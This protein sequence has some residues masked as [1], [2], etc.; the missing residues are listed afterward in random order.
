MTDPVVLEEY[1]G[2]ERGVEDQVVVRARVDRLQAHLGV[3][4]AG[5]HDTHGDGSQT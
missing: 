2:L 4:L 3:R 1:E 5:T